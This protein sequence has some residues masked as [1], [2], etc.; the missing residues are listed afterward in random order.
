MGIAVAAVAALAPV[1]STVGTIATVIGTG[2][3]LFS[4][5]SGGK[6][7]EDNGAKAAAAQARANDI[8]NRQAEVRAAREKAQVLQESRIKRAQIISAGESVGASDTSS[9]QGGSGAVT[10]QAATEVGF[11][12]NIMN[13]ETQRVAQLNNVARYTEA[14]TRAGNKASA[15]SSIG[16]ALTS[17]GSIFSKS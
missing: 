8:A 12:S 10:T 17:L 2:L 3:S 5:L 9:V 7:Q 14:A 13:L 15:G 4:S 16:S 11:Q 6:K 1:L